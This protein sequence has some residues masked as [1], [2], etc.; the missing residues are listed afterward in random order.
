MSNYSVIAPLNTF[1][2]HSTKFANAAINVNVHKPVRIE[3]VDSAI[4]S[5]C[6]E[7]TKE[8]FYSRVRKVLNEICEQDDLMESHISGKMESILGKD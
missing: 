5:S 7:S 4:L 6:Y 8:E 1:D 2:K 3:I